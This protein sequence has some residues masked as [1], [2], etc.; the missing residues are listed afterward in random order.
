MMTRFQL[1]LTLTQLSESSIKGYVTQARNGEFGLHF[2][3]LRKLVTPEE[4]KEITKV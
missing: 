4:A 2:R 1:W 3:M